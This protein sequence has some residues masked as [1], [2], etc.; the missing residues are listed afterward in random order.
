MTLPWAADFIYAVL[1]FE[2]CKK[3]FPLAMAWCSLPGFS[4]HY[5]KGSVLNVVTLQSSFMEG[6]TKICLMFLQV[7]NILYH[8]VKEMVRALKI[9]E[10]ELEDMDENWA[11]SAFLW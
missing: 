3:V 1:C 10:G 9:H 11:H 6:R 5:D 4:I 2:I 8:A 7:K